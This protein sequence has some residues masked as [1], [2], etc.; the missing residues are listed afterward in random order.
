MK[1]LI[2][3]FSTSS[4]DAS[5]STLHV[6]GGIQLKPFREALAKI[7]STTPSIHTINASTT[8]LSLDL[9]TRLL[10]S[11][12]GVEGC[13]VFPIVMNGSSDQGWVPSPMVLDH[14]QLILEKKTL[15]TN[16]PIED[17]VNVVRDDSRVGSKGMLKQKNAVSSVSF[18][19]WI[20]T[21]E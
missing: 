9:V 5:I 3:S 18:G 19:L 14:V 4:G 20:N 1:K 21:L 12:V 16:H 13:N 11:V 10:G 17:I 2:R 7:N 8:A 6:R 15:S